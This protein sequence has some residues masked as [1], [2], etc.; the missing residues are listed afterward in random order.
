MIENER[1]GAAEETVPRL[2]RAD[3]RGVPSN[4]HHL[5]R[6]P[7][8]APQKVACAADDARVV[9]RGNLSWVSMLGVVGFRREAR[10]P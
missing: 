8:P 1:H 2:V 5:E 9:R 7:A 10:K 3:G 6:T 4:G